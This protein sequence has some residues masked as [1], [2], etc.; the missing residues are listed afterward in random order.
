MD[1]EL[2]TADRLKKTQLPEGELT[3]FST[4]TASILG[5]KNTS[6]SESLR[7]KENQS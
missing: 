6:T 1:K 4:S 3:S 7:L 2:N 5:C